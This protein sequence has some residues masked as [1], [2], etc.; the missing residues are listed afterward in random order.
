MQYGGSVYILTNHWN[1]VLY[2]G[3]TSNLIARIGEHRDNT[4]PNSFSSLYNTCKL[5]WYESFPRVEEAIAR[6]KT[7]KKWKRDWKENLIVKM[8]P[9]WKDLYDSL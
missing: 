8:N 1:V 6:E 7:M 4:Y 3:V 5:V 9:E 2:L